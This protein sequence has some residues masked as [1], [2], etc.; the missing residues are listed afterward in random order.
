MDRIAE[1]IDVKELMTTLVAF[2]P[3]VGAALLV[4][5]S[6]WLVYRVSRLALRAALHKA[7]FHEAL[8]QLMVD[9][10]YRYAVMAVSLV[11]AA[12]QLGINVGA[13]L[14]GLGVAGLAL[15]FAAQDSVANVISGIMIFWD[16]PFVVGDWIRTEG[17][18]G[19]VVEITLRSTRM[20]TNRNTYVVIPNKTVIDAVLENYSKHGELRIDIPIGIAYKED[21]GRAREVLLEAVRALPDVM[22]TPPPDVVVESLGDS[23]VNLLVRAWLE[24]AEG[25]QR[26][27]S[28]VVEASKVA[29]DGAGIQIPFP[30][31]QLFIDDVEERVIKKVVKLRPLAGGGAV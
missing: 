18:Y 24:T 21:I 20:Q 15:G 19:R 2:V 16:K 10:L 11:M 30:H 3:R 1:M 4:L 13:A 12:D 28:A 26:A 17:N 22:A 9:N 5:V 23:S 14:A 7:D 31:L 29:L 6:F 27:T 8:I 25:L